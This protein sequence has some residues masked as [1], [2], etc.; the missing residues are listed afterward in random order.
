M[1]VLR[2][3]W[4]AVL[5]LRNE[6]PERRVTEVE[7]GVFVGGLPTRSRW[8]ALHTAGVTHF[9]SLL[10]E[11]PP[12]P[13]L[14]NAEAVLWLPVADTDAPSREQLR[15]GCDFLDAARVK[16]RSVFICCG[17]GMG[18]APTLYLAWRLSREPRDVTSTISAVRIARP[19]VNPTVRQCEALERWAMRDS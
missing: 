2:S 10:A 12:D 8:A 18:R 1:P 14:A 15:A 7:P 17:S 6:M 3:L 16:G 4:L 9:V 19:V 5:R 11:V 13:W